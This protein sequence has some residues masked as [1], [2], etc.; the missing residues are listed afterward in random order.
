MPCS[1]ENK[2]FQK[3]GP[4]L[5]P[6]PGG[7]ARLGSTA[8]TRNLGSCPCCDGNHCQAA[9]CLAFAAAVTLHGGRARLDSPACRY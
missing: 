7:Q 3:V 9:F 8:R 2:G 4:S 6:A 1:A 5:D